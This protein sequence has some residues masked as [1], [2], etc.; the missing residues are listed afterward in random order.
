M[1]ENLRQ[2]L[3]PARLEALHRVAEEIA[4]RPGYPSIDRWLAGIEH[5]ACRAALVYC[6]DLAETVQLIKTHNFE[7]GGPPATAKIADLIGYG[8]SEKYATLR[9][10]LG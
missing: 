1:V 8:V 6:G 2:L 5:T 9:S 4:A 3:A 10:K 7:T